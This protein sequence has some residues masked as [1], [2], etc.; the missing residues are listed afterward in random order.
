MGFVD[1]SR[2]NEKNP[3]EDG[4]K[5]MKLWIKNISLFILVPGIAAGL[6]P[7]WILR[8]TNTPIVFKTD[9]I[10]LFSILLFIGGMYMVI[11]VV[12]A[13]TAIDKGTP[14]PFD[15]PRVFVVRGL[16][17]FMRNP[18]YT[19]ALIMLLAETLYFRSLVLLVYSAWI[20]FALH[21]FTVL[22]EEPGLKKRF[23]QPY[24]D[25]LSTVPRWIP[26]KRINKKENPH[27]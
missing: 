21:L 23:G 11:W 3:L 8:E 6:I 25:Y 16:Y 27:V 2:Y 12:W 19:G 18:M 14:A 13:F 7:F 24:L 9:A 15:P 1:R 17:R 4:L 22:I 10:S 26:I 20:L 5:R